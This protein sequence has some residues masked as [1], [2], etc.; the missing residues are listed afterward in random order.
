MNQDLKNPCSK[1]HDA[2]IKKNRFLQSREEIH[3]FLDDCLKERKVHFWAAAKTKHQPLYDEV[4][5]IKKQL[6][7]DGLSVQDYVL[8]V[9]QWKVKSLKLIRLTAFDLLLNGWR[10]SWSKGT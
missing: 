9:N 5:S 6:D 1:I 4:V 10:T 7:A 8:L 2:S 3:N